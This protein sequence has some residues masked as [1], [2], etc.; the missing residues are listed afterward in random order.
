MV[1][2]PSAAKRRMQVDLPVAMPPVKATWRTRAGMSRLLGERRRDLALVVC[3]R[4]D[5]LFDERIPFVTVRALPNQL[6]AA[7]P[8]PQTDVR[9]EIEHRVVRNR[10]VPGH[11]GLRQAE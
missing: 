8:A 11:E 10:D 7:I 2:M 1:G 3:R 4:S 5:A 9:V 6:G